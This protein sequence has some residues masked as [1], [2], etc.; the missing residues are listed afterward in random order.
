[1]AD[2]KR[3]R[4]TFDGTLAGYEHG[5]QGPPAEAP[6]KGARSAM[7]ALKAKGYT[8]VVFSCR[9]SD[10]GGVQDI[11][12]WLV[13]QGMARY[14]SEVTDVKPKAVAYID[15]RGVPFSGDWLSV[16]TKVDALASKAK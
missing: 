15:D 8:I 9:A 11:E 3:L 2:R 4:S 5:W 16:L 12:R 13:Q 7:Q 14:V 6:T 1:M 10:P